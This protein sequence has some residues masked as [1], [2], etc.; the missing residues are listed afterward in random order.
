ML[1]VA[2]FGERGLPGEAG[3][4][5]VAA[6]AQDTHRAFVMIGKVLLTPFKVWSTR[7]APEIAIGERRIGRPKLVARPVEAN[8][9]AILARGHAHPLFEPAAKMRDRHA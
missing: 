1:A 6:F 9:H 7:Q 8:Q 5:V 4:I 2:F 3:W